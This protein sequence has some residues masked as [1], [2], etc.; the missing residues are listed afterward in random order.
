MLNCE[1]VF[2]E[3]QS[4]GLALFWKDEIQVT[5]LSKSKHHI[6]VE[7]LENDGSGVRWR[8]TSFYGHPSMNE[9]HQTWDLLRDLRD[10]SSLPWV[11]IGDFNQLLY[12]SEKEGGET[13]R[14][15]QMQLFR[16]ALSY[17]ELADLGFFGPM[18]TWKGPGM[19]SWVKRLE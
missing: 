19:R 5:F 16:D 13:C 15:S 2:S 6:D 7:I 3:E 12:N 8:L 4:G 10:Q 1:A 14:E 18:F 11:V 17:C 9:R